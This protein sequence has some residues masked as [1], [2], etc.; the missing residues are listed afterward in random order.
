M[1][2]HPTPENILST[3]LSAAHAMVRN[4]S[5]D[6][7]KLCSRRT[8]ICSRWRRL[9]ARSM[10][11]SVS[12][13]GAGCDGADPAR[14]AI[15][16]TWACCRS[17][18]CC[19]VP[20][21]RARSAAA[22]SASYAAVVDTLARRRLSSACVQDGVSIRK[23][24]EKSSSRQRHRTLPACPGAIQRPRLPRRLRASWPVLPAAPVGDAYKRTTMADSPAPAGAMS[25]SA[26]WTRTHPPYCLGAYARIS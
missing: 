14:R 25:A 8:S 6:R 22:R 13:P 26:R 2:K 9:W 11:A 23:K 3:S 18:S 24:G 16:A 1:Q 10:A 4:T 19:N 17:W 15:S 12:A 5:A 7:A 20:R 21:A